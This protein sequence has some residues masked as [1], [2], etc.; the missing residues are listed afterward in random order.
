MPSP[1]KQIVKDYPITIKKYVP[2]SN[3]ENQVSVE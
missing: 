1:L 3:K 2:E